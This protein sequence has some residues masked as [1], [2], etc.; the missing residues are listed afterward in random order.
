MD[1]LFLIDQSHTGLPIEPKFDDLEI[2]NYDLVVISGPARKAQDLIKILLTQQG[3]NLI[4]PSYGTVLGGAP[5]QR[6]ISSLNDMIADTVK[7]AT[8]WLQQQE[9]ST[10]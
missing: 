6:A 2:E 1:D 7:E 8:A 5:G 10:R 3:Q 9:E 4:Y